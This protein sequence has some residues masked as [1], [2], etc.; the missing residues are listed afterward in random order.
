VGRITIRFHRQSKACFDIKDNAGD[1]W[2]Q[3]VRMVYE[4][5]WAG[6][7][8]FKLAGAKCL[9]LTGSALNRR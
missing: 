3:I 9:G 8:R 7:I 6:S 1:V 2:G 4:D 5:L